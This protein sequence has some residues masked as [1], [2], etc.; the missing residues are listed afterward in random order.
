MFHLRYTRKMFVERY[1]ELDFVQTHFIEIFYDS[2]GIVY[3]NHTHG[4]QNCTVVGEFN[5]RMSFSQIGNDARTDFTFR[6]RLQP[7][8]HHSY[9]LLEELP[10]DMIE[11]FV[12][13]DPLHLLELGLMKKLMRIWIEGEITRDFKLPKNDK[14]KLDNA[15][16][17]CNSSLPIE[18]HRSVRSLEWLKFWKGNEFRTT[19][20]YTGIIVFKNI[21]HKHVYEHFL[22]LFCAVTICSADVYKS[23][24]PLAKALFEEFI[25]IYV[26]LYGESSITM[27]V[28]NLC[29]VTDNVLRFGN[30]NS[31]S[32]YPFENAARH[33]KLKLKQCNRSLEQ[34]AKRIEEL[35]LLDNEQKHVAENPILKFP[36][37][38]PEEPDIT[39][40]KYI[41][42]DQ[43]V[44]LSNK[45]QGDKWFLTKKGQL[46]KFQHAYELNSI[47]LIT[48]L[49]L[50][51]KHDFFK[52][53]FNSSHIFIYQS[54]IIFSDEKQYSIDEI[55]CKMI[56]LNYEDKCVFLPLLHSF[57]AFN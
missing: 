54:E 20:L 1:N 27:N 36:F 7:E 9:S 41:C 6:H 22:Y 21:L 15:L 49:P 26:E 56:C 42:I 18:I 8:H 11:D 23:Y 35:S 46:S 47:V 45:K 25:E 53:P 55:K 34:V 13:A 31:I 37:D 4:C 19:L 12:I 3:F 38:H 16:L 52:K 57:D 50:R 28:H 14:L 33:I 29:H 17:E 10:I 24:V 44:I 39:L 51:D 43:S 5:N 48:G 32:T 2:T 40:Y 30:L